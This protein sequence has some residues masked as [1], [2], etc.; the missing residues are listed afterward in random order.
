MPDIGD[1]VRVASM[2]VGQMPR[3]GVV[4]DVTGHLLRVRWSTGEESNI[5]PGPGVVAVIGKVRVSSVKKATAPS[6]AAKATKSP[7]KVAKKVTK[8]PSR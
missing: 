5:V 7:K 8:K 3:E 1:R 2:K 4:I 6:K